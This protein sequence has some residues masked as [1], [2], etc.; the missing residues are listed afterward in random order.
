MKIHTPEG[1][2]GLGRGFGPPRGDLFS[3]ASSHST[4]QIIC[5]LELMEEL[6]ELVQAQ[7]HVYAL[8]LIL[9]VKEVHL[10]INDALA[11]RLNHTIRSRYPELVLEGNE[12]GIVHLREQGLQLLR[13]LALYLE[14]LLD[15]LEDGLACLLWA[16]GESALLDQCSELLFTGRKLLDDID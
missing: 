15:R 2:L 4:H 5:S 13:L 16:G 7:L 14:G 1:N 8:S 10:E 3:R 11:V 9:L 6:I 12:L